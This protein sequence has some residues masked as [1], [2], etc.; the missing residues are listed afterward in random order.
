MKNM[1]KI[2]LL[3]TLVSL[4]FCAQ[5]V[6]AQNEEPSCGINGYVIDKDP[7]GLNVR[8]K[9]NVNGK[10]IAK[11][12]HKS[13]EDDDIV[14]VYITGYSNGWV[15]IARADTVGGGK[16]FDDIGWVSAKMVVTG[17][18]GSEDYDKPAPLYAQANTKSKIGTIPSDAEVQI[19]GFACGWIKVTYKGKSGWIKTQNICGNPVTTCN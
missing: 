6:F 15:K 16:I 5:A 1:Q 19:A 3:L 13:N 7:K 4:L 12:P 14:T 9:P 10:I 8:D 11:L 17:T 18:K 2:L